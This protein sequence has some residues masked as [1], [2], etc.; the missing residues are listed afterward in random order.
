MQT[1]TTPQAPTS[2]A[3]ILA[4]ERANTLSHYDADQ[5]AAVLKLYNLARQHLGT[6]GGNTAAK[7]LLGLYNGNRFP[8]DLTS[9]RY[10]DA[11]NLEAA[12]TVMLMD[13]A[14]TYVEVHELLNAILGV[15]Y[16]GVQFEVWA[17]DLKLKGRGTKDGYIDDKKR[18][19][20]WAAAS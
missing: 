12:F 20:A 1:T 2:R 7:L 3:A 5:Q 13:A 4:A 16:V 9:L 15:Q 10:L 8:F 11:G 14:R 18:L 19:A 17:F 6:S